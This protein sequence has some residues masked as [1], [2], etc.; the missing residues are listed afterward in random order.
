MFLGFYKG[1]H[2]LAQIPIA[3]LALAHL[4]G[5]DIK[6]VVGVAVRGILVG[7]IAVILWSVRRLYCCPDHL[8]GALPSC[9]ATAAS[10]T[11]DLA[12]MPACRP[13]HEQDEVHNTTSHCDMHE[14]LEPAYAN[15]T[16][17]PPP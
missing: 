10:P 17:N 14:L 3:A 13:E 6:R 12:D 4:G 9:H 2:V 1:V 8:H 7:V 16:P 11:A 5:R 15:R